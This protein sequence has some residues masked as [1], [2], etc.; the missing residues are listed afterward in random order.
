MIL[1]F[2][3]KSGLLNL[4]KNLTDINTL[5]I[6]NA[7]VTDHEPKNQPVEIELVDKQQ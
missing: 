6:T 4:M 3:T 2:G 7:A 5:N 1:R